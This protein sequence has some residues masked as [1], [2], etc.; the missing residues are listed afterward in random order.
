MQDQKSE[1]PPLTSFYLKF[2]PLLPVLFMAILLPFLAK[3]VSN[4]QQRLALQSPASQKS[5]EGT[6]V[7]LIQDNFQ[8]HK[9]QIRYFLQTDTQITELTKTPSSEIKPG[10]KIRLNQ[11]QTVE[12]FEQPA[13]LTAAAGTKR[14]AV[15][16]VNFIN[17]NEREP[18]DSVVGRTM[19][20][21]G[22]FYRE[23]SFA[24]LSF[25]VTRSDIYGWYT[26]DINSSCDLADIVTHTIA[27]SDKDINFKRYNNLIIVFPANNCGFDG[28]ASIGE[29]TNVNT[30]DGYVNLGM[31]I[32][33]NKTFTSAIVS[34]ELGHNLTAIHG[35]KLACE[36]YSLVKNCT[37]LE[38]F[39]PYD[40]MGARFGHFS[41][42]HKELFGWQP[43]ITTPTTSGD[44]TIYSIERSPDRLQA[45]KIPA[46]SNNIYVEK[47]EKF[48]FDS[49]FDDNTINGVLIHFNPQEMMGGDS[50]I[51]S[52][53]YFGYQSSVNLKQG[54][55]AIYDYSDGRKL[56]ITTLESG[57]D[58]A[59]VNVDFSPYPAPSRNVTIIDNL[60]TTGAVE[61]EVRGY[62]NRLIQSK[63]A[64]TTPPS[65]YGPN[66]W[67]LPKPLDPNVNAFVRFNSKSLAKGS[68]EV[69][70][71]WTANPQNA[72]NT[73]VTITQAGGQPEVVKLVDQ[74][75]EGK[76]W[77][78][79]GTFTLDNTSRVTISTEGA[80]GDVS[81]D[82][83]RFIKK[84]S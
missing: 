72:S 48:G 27:A 1:I 30:A 8:D 12:T 60:D 34:H 17:T 3:T 21:V 70:V 54:E 49:Q 58:Y 36:N 76:V 41:A 26:L 67:L 74:K 64:P 4:R 22:R 43:N 51:V 2:L 14:V 65:Y 28:T 68:Y 20:D 80:N 55:S 79:L 10:T 11:D 5:Q 46:D 31:S 83:V 59:K 66:Y 50:H 16:K 62:P 63:V 53:Y 23:N 45:L 40:V 7:S 52:P 24:K 56:A 42:Y 75:K 32:V 6:L 73:K 15:V 44:Y 39:D 18:L 35:N 13:Q 78:L 57:P 19:S 71:R 47:R 82:A 25:T 61:T 29:W 84:G 38:Y 77:K 33:S 37:S 9:S 69:S 81:V